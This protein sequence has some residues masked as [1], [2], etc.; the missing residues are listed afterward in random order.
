M[1]IQALYQ[2]YQHLSA[3]P[4]SG[5]S[6][7]HFS[8]GKVTYLLILNRDGELIDVQDI[9]LQEGK[10]KRPLV[11]IVPEQKTRSSGI[12]PYFLCDKAEYILGHYALMPGEQETAKKRKDAL[13]K[14]NASRELA[15]TVLEKTNS[16][17]VQ[18]LLKF[19]DVWNP[20]AVREHPALQPFMDDLDKGIDTNMIFCVDSVTDLLHEQKEVKEAWLRRCLELESDV[21]YEAQ[22]LLTGEVTSIARLHDKIKGVRGAQAA[23]LRSSRSTLH[24]RNLMARTSNRASTLLLEQQ[25]CSAIRPH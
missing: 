22:C 2:R 4:D 3:N 13:D 18:A 8:S 24:R 14:Y 9:R 1:I 20:E 21:E 16:V 12:K 23:E 25:R 19:Y 6:P 10:K 15:L 5:V 7:L 11:L 17:L